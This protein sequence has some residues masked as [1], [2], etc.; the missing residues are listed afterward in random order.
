MSDE[1][2]V[3]RERLSNAPKEKLI[4][5]LIKQKDILDRMKVEAE[6]HAREKT[7]I[8]DAFLSA[9]ASGAAIR[10]QAEKEGQAI[11][12]EATTRAEREVKELTGRITE[13]RGDVDR[14]RRYAND[15]LTEV[16]N[17][18]SQY[19]TM[20]AQD[21]V[22][23]MDALAAKEKEFLSGGYSVKDEPVFRVEAVEAPV[24]TAS[25]PTKPSIQVLPED[26]NTLDLGELLDSTP[27]PVTEP[28]PEFEPIAEPE[29]VVEHE[30]VAPEP[31]VPE[32][33][34]D[35]LDLL[36]LMAAIPEVPADESVAEEAPGLEV[37]SDPEPVEEETLDLAGLLSAP[38][39]EPVAEPEPFV[40]PEPEP[41]PE[42][43]L[44][45]EESEPE[46]FVLPEPEPEPEPEP[47]FVLPEPAI[48]ADS[49]ESMTSLEALLAVPVSV[50]EPAEESAAVPAAPAGDVVDLSSL[51]S[52]VPSSDDEITDLSSLMSETAPATS[53]ESSIDLSALLD[54]K[55]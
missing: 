20:V 51:L 32:P 49:V 15:V 35:E 48:E 26:P 39:S 19:S 38:V 27:E 23:L 22:E 28:E 40:L 25:E 5:S 16:E 46:P 8:A 2:D 9:Q 18:V 37:V 36:A 30:A 7:S 10:A 21:R 1:A 14:Y 34:S 6:Q 42:P 4:E 50:P 33:A 43:E 47:S 55:E 45:A 44:V 31:V 53:D 29:P 54:P 17:T 12:A 41:E 13:L 52:E 24:A 3:V 11:I